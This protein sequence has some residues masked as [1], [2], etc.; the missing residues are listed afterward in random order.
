M[1]IAKTPKPF[2]EEL[3]RRMPTDVQRILQRDAD[4]VGRGFDQLAFVVNWAAGVAPQ[5]LNDFFG[6]N[7]GAEGQA[8]GAGQA[9]HHYIVAGAGFANVGKYF[10][11]QTLRVFVDG[12][13]L[14]R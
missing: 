11:N 1:L 14:W 9:V 7:S 12:D 13:N 2:G 10:P 8:D 6:R 5:L 3:A 4:G